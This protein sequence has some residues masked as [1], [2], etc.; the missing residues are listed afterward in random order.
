MAEN[1]YTTVDVAKVCKVSLRTVIRWADE[2]KLPSFRTPGGHRRVREGDLQ[3]F[4]HRYK[5]PF[6]VESRGEKK[7]ILV[8]EGKKTLEAAL[9]HLLRRSSDSL[10]FFFAPNLYEAAVRI[11][12]VIP[13]L[14]I[15]VADRKDKELPRFLRTLRGVQETKHT[16]ILLLK[17]S[18]SGLSDQ[19]IL[20]LGVNTVL[21]K[22]FSSDAFRSHLLELLQKASSRPTL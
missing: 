4:L 7:R 11:G 21:S 15:V 22:P 18:S 10:E 12:L 17:S 3:Q 20:S 9:R 5:I 6:T 14:V 2:G 1:I 16:N 19:E 8:I 13:D